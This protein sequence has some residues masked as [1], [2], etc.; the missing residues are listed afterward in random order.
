MAKPCLSEQGLQRTFAEANCPIFMPF[1]LL[2]NPQKTG[3]F[4]PF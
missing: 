4:I 2:K 1:K 3:K